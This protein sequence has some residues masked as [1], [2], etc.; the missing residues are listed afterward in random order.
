M[1]WASRGEGYSPALTG[2]RL[3]KSRPKK[4]LERTAHRWTESWDFAFAIGS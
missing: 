3:D 4:A 2:F 1:C